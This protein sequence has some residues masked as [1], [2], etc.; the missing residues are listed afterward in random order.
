MIPIVFF[1]IFIAVPVFANLLYKHNGK[2]QIFNIDLVQFIYAFVL[3]PLA[4]LWLKS[5]LYFVLRSEL[6]FGWSVRDLFF[7]DSLFSMMMTY[8]LMA[9]AIHSV[10]KSFRLRKD[11]DPLYDVYHLSE[12]FHL[13]FTHIVI[14]VGSL[15]FLTVL[16]LL[17][18]LLPLQAVQ[19]TGW[20]L[21]VQ[22]CG[23]LFGMI[24]FFSVWM[25]DPKQEKRNFM[26]F[27]KLSAGAFFLFHVSVYFFVD[28]RF[29]LAY[30][31]YWFIS[32]CSFGIVVSFFVF[33]RSRVIRALRSRLLHPSWGNNIE[34][35][36]KL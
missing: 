9:I 11:E 2:R 8:L 26:R 30:G 36:K 21:F 16:S 33:P 24:W 18:L 5:L 6:N 13:W 14:F 12:Y 23:F 35:P 25:S 32:A 27:M 7:I 1:I 15:L 19:S 17:N 31:V 3:A 10:T 28:P 29:S 4:F 34:V 20:F 22:I